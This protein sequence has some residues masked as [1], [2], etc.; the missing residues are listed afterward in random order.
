MLLH[1]TE[2]QKKIIGDYLE[3]TFNSNE[4]HLILRFKHA[5]DDIIKRLTTC[6]AQ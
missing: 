1:L 3:L 2:I 4:E 5:G 6:Y